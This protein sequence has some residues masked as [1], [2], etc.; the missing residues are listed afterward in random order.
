MSTVLNKLSSDVLSLSRLPPGSSSRH[1]LSRDVEHNWLSVKS[2]LVSVVTE[3]NSVDLID[4]ASKEFESFEQIIEQV[5]NKPPSTGT[6]SKDHRSAH[7]HLMTSIKAARNQLADEQF[8]QFQSQLHNLRNDISHQY[9]HFFRLSQIDR[10]WKTTVV[11]ECRRSLDRLMS[12]GELWN[13]I[14]SIKLPDFLSEVAA[15]ISTLTKRR[16]TASLIPR[17]SPRRQGQSRGASSILIENPKPQRATPVEKRPRAASFSRVTPAEKPKQPQIDKTPRA[18]S[19]SRVVSAE[20]PKRAQIEKTPCAAS[21]SQVVSVEKP[22]RQP[23]PE[24]DPIFADLREFERRVAQYNAGIV[25]NEHIKA[26]AN[27]LRAMQKVRQ[28]EPHMTRLKGLLAQIDGEVA[29]SDATRMLDKEFKDAA[30]GLEEAS[31]LLSAA[32]APDAR[33]LA[34]EVGMLVTMIGSVQPSPQKNDCEG[35]LGLVAKISEGIESQTEVYRRLISEMR[36][37]QERINALRAHRK[38]AKA[39]DRDEIDAEVGALQDQQTGLIE[40]LAAHQ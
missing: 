19:V 12:Y 32:Q 10:A 34:K 9:E 35:V 28:R 40:K 36:A 18:A 38:R 6:L 37:V 26:F 29:A 14:G 15:G 16:P 20:K 27:E 31:Q 1:L 23:P 13:E 2:L 24:S 21:V 11:D 33:R 3:I 17:L 7:K 4:L 5:N 8:E 30:V 25:A 39:K 22:K